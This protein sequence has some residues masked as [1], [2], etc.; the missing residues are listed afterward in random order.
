M[1]KHVCRECGDEGGYPPFE[2][3]KCSI[4]G[5][6]FCYEDFEGHGCAEEGDSARIKACLKCGSRNLDPTPGGAYAAL[7]NYG[8]FLSG[9]EVCMDCGHIGAPVK[10]EREEDYQSFVEHLEGLKGKQDD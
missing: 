6:Y 4:C 5:D 8:I 1:T 3:K 9:Y 7:T 2:L 10:F